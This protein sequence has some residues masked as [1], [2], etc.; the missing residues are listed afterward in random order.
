MSVAERMDLND[1][2]VRDQG[3]QFFHCANFLFIYFFKKGY[4]SPGAIYKEP[5][6]DDIFETN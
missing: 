4:D 2:L 1:L 6:A 5:P 3:W